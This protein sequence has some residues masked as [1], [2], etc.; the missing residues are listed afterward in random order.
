M[1]GRIWQ[2]DYS[3]IGLFYD[4][5]YDYDYLILLLMIKYDY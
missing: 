4:D 1:K 5:D 2:G 3:H